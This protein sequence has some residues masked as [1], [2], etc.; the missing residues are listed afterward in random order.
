[1]IESYVYLQPALI[2]T[3]SNYEDVS[4]DFS[5]AEWELMKKVVRVLKPFQEATVMLSCSDASI[6]QVIPFVTTITESLAEETNDDVGVLGMKRDLKKAMDTRFKD[7]ESLEHYTI[8]TLLDAKYKG[9]FFQKP[10]TLAVTKELLTDVLVNLL[11][12]NGAPNEV[13]IIL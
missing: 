4:I 2:Q 11:K 10:D 8:S 6:S 9:C 12:E 13:I 5:R 1:M 7:V 3:L